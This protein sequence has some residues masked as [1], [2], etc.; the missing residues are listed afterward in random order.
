METHASVQRYMLIWPVCRG[1]RGC[2]A[3]AT[4]ADFETM[5][6]TKIDSALERSLPESHVAI[7]QPCTQHKS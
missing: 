6:E 3:Q 7:N 2:V 5:S 4:C 1:K